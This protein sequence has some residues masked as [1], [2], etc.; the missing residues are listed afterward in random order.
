MEKLRERVG[1]TKVEDLTCNQHHKRGQNLLKD[2]L[3]KIKKITGVK[4]DLKPTNNIIS[5]P[6]KTKSVELGVRCGL[7]DEDGQFQED[8]NNTDMTAVV[9]DDD[10][11]ESGKGNLEPTNL[12]FTGL[13]THDKTGLI[14]ATLQVSFRI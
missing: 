2:P 8:I 6:K 9:T 13:I 3:S 7:F 10:Q 11:S 5:L 1:A 12:S 14:S 4:R